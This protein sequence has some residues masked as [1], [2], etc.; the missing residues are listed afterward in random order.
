MDET[1]RIAAA[2]RGDEAAFEDLV[3]EHRPAARRC[4]ELLGA[5][6]EAEDVVQDAL[7]K[8]YRKLGTYRGDAGFRSWLLAIVANET[9][10]LH[11]SRSRRGAAHARQAALAG[12]PPEEPLPAEDRELLLTAI[13]GLS[14]PDRDVLTYRYLLD[15]SES[16]TA[17]L[18][19]WPKG[20][21]KS[22]TSRALDR[23]RGRL[24]IALALLV[25][26]AVVLAVPPA[27]RVVA[28]VFERIIRI[29]GVVV[30]RGA[31][32][33]PSGSPGPVSASPSES[34]MAVPPWVATPAAL[35][36]PERAVAL[37]PDAQGRPRVVSLFYRGGTVRVDVFDGRGVFEKH[38]YGQ[39]QRV[40]VRELDDALWL[41][42]PHDLLYFDRAMTQRT[43]VA[44]LAGPTLIWVRSGITYRLEGVGGRDE[45]LAI[46]RSVP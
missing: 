17:E 7:V 18:L 25:A 11:R 33:Q 29:G 23:L 14:A 36:T 9:R 13:R 39:A 27:R 37:D 22:R 30:H 5:G 6:T 16:E 1:E 2:R 43:G 26:A 28:D 4:A 19:G 8:A 42:G 40:A 46:L 12:R 10:N 20:T 21:V 35:G 44:R 32:G 24:G 38:V 45:A 34:P 15:H 31:P 41:P 3:R